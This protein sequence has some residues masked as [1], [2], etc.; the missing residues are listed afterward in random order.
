MAFVV[1]PAQTQ[2]RPQSPICKEPRHEVSASFWPFSFKLPV[3][4]LQRI[5]PHQRTWQ[6]LHISHDETGLFL[7]TV[8]SIPLATNFLSVP[9]LAFTS[10]MTAQCH[11]F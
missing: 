8:P 10:P 4:N 2:H 6:L 1:S 9:S 11:Y 5:D 3:L 7:A